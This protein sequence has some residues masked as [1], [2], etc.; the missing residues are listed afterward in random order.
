MLV[1]SSKPFPG[2]ENQFFTFYSY[3]CPN[4]NIEDFLSQNENFGCICQFR[5]IH[6]TQHF[7]IIFRSACLIVHNAHRQ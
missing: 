4:L 3:E 7:I 5:F 1:W 2:P 6:A